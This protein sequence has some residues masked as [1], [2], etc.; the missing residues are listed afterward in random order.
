MN[1]NQKQFIKQEVHKNQTFIFSKVGTSNTK[2]KQ[3][4]FKKIKK[5]S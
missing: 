4:L 5:L 3:N 2:K 1:T